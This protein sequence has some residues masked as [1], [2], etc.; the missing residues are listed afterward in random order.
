MKTRE[1]ILIQALIDAAH[2]N[3]FGPPETC[4]AASCV[5][6]RAIIAQLPRTRWGQ[7]V[8]YLK[9]LYR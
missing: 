2:W 7:I 3:H 5:D 6:A 8:E 4:G 1:S 9:A